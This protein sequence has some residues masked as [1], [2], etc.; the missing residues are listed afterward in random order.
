MS[1]LILEQL[2]RLE[3]LPADD[4]LLHQVSR[5]MLKFGKLD[6]PNR[7]NLNRS[8]KLLILLDIRREFMILDLALIRAA[9]LLCRRMELTDFMTLTSNSR[10]VKIHEFSSMDLGNQHRLQIWPYHRMEKF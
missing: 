1:T 8:R 6:S 9:W 2:I 10:K 4:S 3:F 5:P 7:E